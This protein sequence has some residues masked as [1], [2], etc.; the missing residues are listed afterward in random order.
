MKS[1]NKTL[2]KWLLERRGRGMALA[3][4]LNCSRQY[5]STI[6]KMDTGISLDKWD[7]ISWAMLEVESDE[8]G[9][10]ACKTTT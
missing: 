8:K 4:E 9:V 2:R 6:S 10:T 5:I 3:G 7:E 1:L